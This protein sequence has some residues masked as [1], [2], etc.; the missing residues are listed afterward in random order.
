MKEEHAER[1]KC[2]TAMYFGKKSEKEKGKSR[3]AK[4]PK[5]DYGAE[6][7]EDNPVD[8][9]AKPFARV[10]QVVEPVVESV[11]Q[12]N[13]NVQELQ[14]VEPVLQEVAQV[15]EPA[16]QEVAWAD[17]IAEVAQVVEPIKHGT[18]PV[19]EDRSHSNCRFGQPL[20]RN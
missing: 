9:E 5:V 1:V 7:F 15:S 19:V 13:A 17:A 16:F 20:H 12:A 8:Q 6:N 11:A 3:K 10:A 2:I 4:K 14:V 18:E